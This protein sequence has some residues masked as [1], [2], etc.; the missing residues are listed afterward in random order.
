MKIL[1]DMNLAPRWQ[2]FFAEHGIEAV[3]WSEIGLPTARDIEIVEFAR[4]KN[5]IIFTHDLDFSALLS[6]TRRL[7]PSVIQV[8][9]QD[10]TPKAIGNIVLAA[11]NEHRE[12][13][14]AGAIVSINSYNLRVRILP[15]QSE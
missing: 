14:D 2:D 10:V 8:R 4:D 12:E 9:T 13:I 1:I 7:G 3:H 5:Y 11:L 6:R 15:L